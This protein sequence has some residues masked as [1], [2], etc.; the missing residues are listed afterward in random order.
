MFSTLHLAME[1]VCYTLVFH[2]GPMG[3]F[4]GKSLSWA[5]SRMLALII[6][7]W[8]ITSV[9]DFVPRNL[10]AAQMKCK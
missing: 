10:H 7:T 5:R 1:I 8:P 3:L 6:Q 9:M 2:S 4:A